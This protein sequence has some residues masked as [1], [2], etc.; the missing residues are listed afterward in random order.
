MLVFL[1]DLM[2]FVVLGGFSLGA[3][4]WMDMLSQLV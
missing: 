3:L 2:A 1:K 4:A